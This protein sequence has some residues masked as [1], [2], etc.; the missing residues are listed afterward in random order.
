MSAIIVVAE[1]EITGDQRPSKFCQWRTVQ[2][3][4]DGE[5]A[6]VNLHRDDVFPDEPDESVLATSRP[7]T[8]PTDGRLIFTTASD[9]EGK[10]RPQTT[11]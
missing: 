5:Q 6:L 3:L 1:L 10:A 2:H 9:P 11:A 7:L 4:V 8:S